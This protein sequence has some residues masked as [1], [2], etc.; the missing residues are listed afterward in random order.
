MH[1]IPCEFESMMTKID[2]ATM[3]GNDDGG[4]GDALELSSSTR[5]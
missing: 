3:Y 1:A 5:S 4:A 2:G